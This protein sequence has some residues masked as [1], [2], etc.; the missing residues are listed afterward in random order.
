MI[1][2]GSNVS[3]D[4][5]SS[6]QVSSFPYEAIPTDYTA[7]SVN[8][9]PFTNIKLP[10]GSD[11]GNEVAFLYHANNKSPDFLNESN[12]ISIDP[13]DIQDSMLGFYKHPQ[14]DLTNLGDYAGG[15]AKITYRLNA[16]SSGEICFA[17]GTR[18]NQVNNIGDKFDTYSTQLPFT[19]V[20]LSGSGENAVVNAVEVNNTTP[21]TWVTASIYLPTIAEMQAKNYKN[22]DAEELIDNFY[23]ANES[24]IGGTAAS[25][26]L[27]GVVSSDDPSVKIDIQ[28]IWWESP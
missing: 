12:F 22:N 1:F 23:E 10:F 11:Y 26:V 6:V 2:D 27:F 21:D 14:G 28:R 16:N 19:S 17:L 4:L 25:A 18:F 5:Y 15:Y 3:V 9:S 8:P 7:Y 13:L 20:S 24:S